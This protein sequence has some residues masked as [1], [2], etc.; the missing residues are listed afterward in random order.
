MKRDRHYIDFASTIDHNNGN[1]VITYFE[2]VYDE[3][4]NS[5]TNIIYINRFGKIIKEQKTGLGRYN[6]S[7]NCLVTGKNELFFMDAD[8]ITLMN[9][10]GD[11]QFIAHSVL[12][13]DVNFNKDTV[14]AKRNSSTAIF[15]NRIF[16]FR[17]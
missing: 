7:L 2:Q 12:F 15:A 17:A 1:P 4:Y 16:P 14:N 9:K 5:T 8:S 11:R 10:N 6:S 13:R 3:Q